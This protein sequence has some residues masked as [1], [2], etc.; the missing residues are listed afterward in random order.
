MDKISEEMS[1]ES[2]RESRVRREEEK[3]SEEIRW[4]NEEIERLKGM[5]AG[6]E[7]EI[8]GKQQ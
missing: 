6:I 7:A 1:E 8:K 2:A 3:A 5:L 4:Q